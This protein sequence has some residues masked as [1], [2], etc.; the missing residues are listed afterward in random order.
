MDKFIFRA[1]L[2]ALDMEEDKN[3][4]IIMG[5]PFLATGRTFIDVALGE[6]I[7]KVN[8]EQVVFNVFKAMEYPD[9]T[10]DFFAVNVI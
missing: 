7:M 1:N 2:V 4:P 6:M 9:A 3:V 5:R 8:E 10:D